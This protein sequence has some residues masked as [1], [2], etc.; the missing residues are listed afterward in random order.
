LALNGSIAAF[1]KGYDTTTA[2]TISS[3]NLPGILAGDVVTMT[4]GTATFDS[5][6]AGIGKTVT[7]TG[8]ALSGA[9]SGNYALFNP[10]ETTTASVSPVA[11]SGNVTVGGKTYDGTTAATLQSRTLTGIL[12]TDVVSLTGGTATFDTKTAGAAKSATITGLLLAGTDGVNYTLSNPTETASAAI[13][14]ASLTG[15]IT[16][17][18]KTYDSTTSA[19]ILT[20]NL[21]GVI[22][23]DAVSLSGGSASFDTKNI[24][25]AKTVTATGLVLSGTDS[26]NY[27]LV[28]PT[29]TTTA[30]ITPL[31]V[32][33]A[34]AAVDDLRLSMDADGIDIDWAIFVAGN[35]A[36]V[37]QLSAADAAGLTI[38]GQGGNDTI[39][40][41][42][43]HGNPLPGTL[44]LNGTFTI[45]GLATSPQ[46]LANTTLEVGTSTV[47][48][49]YAPGQSP[50]ALIQQALARGYN[51][52]SWSGSPTAS[53]GSMTSANAASGAAGA[54]AVGYADSADGLV[55][56]QP[57]NTVEVRY[58][59]M[60]DANLDRVVNST[61]AVQMAR[62]YN[63]SINP[64]WDQGNFNYDAS[65]NMADA[66]LLQKNF[67][68]TASGAAAAALAPATTP[69]ASPTGSGSS[70]NSTSS[71][72]SSASSSST[73]PVSTSSSSSSSS[74]AS[75]SAG[76][77]AVVVATPVVATPVMVAPV[78]R[79]VPVT[80]PTIVVT[81]PI[82]VTAAPVTA[83]MAPTAAP[84]S[85]TTSAAIAPVVIA[86]P[87]S[88]TAPVQSSP[89]VTADGFGHADDLRRR[90]YPDTHC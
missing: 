69:S 4:G 6:N 18:S 62:N 27:T 22:G 77:V 82:V 87:V 67:N 3:R 68:A 50:A 36:Q 24:G 58:T 41:D 14:Q 51:A 31:R 33:N 81:S 30:A 76:V 39:G 71:R 32:L 23:T 34:T 65:V 16:A 25:T 2:A 17:A 66:V 45:N 74:S 42:Y 80:T 75:T 72:S 43:S 83:P 28:N 64:A 10:T 88:T 9:D 55:S 56:G 63:N 85:G 48:F 73:A 79:Q 1:G 70:S 49:S 35:P 11:L 5:K 13:A 46:A 8:L 54:L 57:L 26:G 40:L 89:V 7:A 90:G 52:G 29:E 47:Y 15:S 78:V 59:V 60:G 53:V 84:A 21:N 12:G 20:A 19:S 61:D 38:N 86:V 44:H 37:G